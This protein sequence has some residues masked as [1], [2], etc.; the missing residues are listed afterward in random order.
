M[1]TWWVPCTFGPRV[2][3]CFFDAVLLLRVRNIHDYPVSLTS[4]SDAKMLYGGKT[5]QL[6]YDITAN[7]LYY[8]ANPQQGVQGV[9]G[10]SI[11]DSGMIQPLDHIDG[12]V[13]FAFPAGLV[14]PNGPDRIDL[15]LE[16]SAGSK[17]PVR[18]T[19]ANRANI[20]YTMIHIP[21]IPSGPM[22]R[23]NPPFAEFVEGRVQ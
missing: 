1:P 13:C 10:Y 23:F 12:V 19:R 2:T 11:R 3:A 21:Q 18:W 16:D 17:L 4:L 9:R 8:G 22:K 14:M 20:S 15:V 5:Y 7:P 6:R